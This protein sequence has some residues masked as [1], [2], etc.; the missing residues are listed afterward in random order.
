M[1]LSFSC[2]VLLFLLSSASVAKKKKKKGSHRF[3]VFLKHCDSRSFL[4]IPLFSYSF[5]GFRGEKNRRFFKKRRQKNNCHDAHP[6]FSPA[7]SRLPPS[8]HPSF[9]VRV[10]VR[11]KK[12]KAGKKKRVTDVFNCHLAVEKRLSRRLLCVCVCVC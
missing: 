5:S 12:K 4:K 8:R 9:P 2:F 7:D 1:S 6:F 3:W 11:V 10:R